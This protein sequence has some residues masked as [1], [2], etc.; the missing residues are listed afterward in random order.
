MINCV[1]HCLSHRFRQRIFYWPAATTST[2]TLGLIPDLQ[3]FKDSIQ[4]VSFSWYQC[5]VRVCRIADAPSKLKYWSYFWKSCTNIYVKLPSGQLITQSDNI[6]SSVRRPFLPWKSTPFVHVRIAVAAGELRWRWV[7]GQVQREQDVSLSQC[8][9]TDNNKHTH[10]H[11][12]SWCRI[13][14]QTALRIKSISI[15]HRFLYVLIISGHSPKIPVVPSFC[16]TLFSLFRFLYCYDCLHF[17]VCAWLPPEHSFTSAGVS[18]FHLKMFCQRIKGNT[19]GFVSMHGKT[20][21]WEKKADFLVSPNENK[22]TWDPVTVFM[23]DH[24]NLCC[25]KQAANDCEF[26]CKWLQNI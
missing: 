21:L 14:G 16:P 9:D 10:T 1:S 17:H 12:V 4:R 5:H 19:A 8:S 26:H 25:T 24:I 7:K 20:D 23:W 18:L 6:P 13:A 3:Y 11:L 22:Q 15:S 2:S